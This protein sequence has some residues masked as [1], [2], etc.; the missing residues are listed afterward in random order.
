MK[1]TEPLA[2][3]P[4]RTTTESSSALVPGAPGDALTHDRD[5]PNGRPI[6]R[7]VRQQNYDILSRWIVDPDF[8]LDW[9]A[10]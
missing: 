7:R 10:S 5:R 2:A 6:R 4:S 9:G 3:T 8:D 1:P